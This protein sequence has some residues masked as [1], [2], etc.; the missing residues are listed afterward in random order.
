MD[1]TAAH[2]SRLALALKSCVAKFSKT[3]PRAPGIPIDTSI[4]QWDPSD[5]ERNI[6]E[7]SE[8]IPG[9]YS[10]F[11]QLRSNSPDKKQVHLKP[12]GILFMAHD[13]VS[14]LVEPFGVC[15]GTSI[16]VNT[17]FYNPI[18]GKGSFAK[19]IE[20]GRILAWYDHYVSATEA[21][22]AGG[23]FGGIGMAAASSD[24]DIIGL[25]L[26]TG[27]IRPV[28]I[29]SLQQLL[30]EDQELLNQYN[31]EKDKGDVVTMMK[32]VKLFNERNSL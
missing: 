8:R 3:D 12:R 26:K 32:Y 14:K 19:V 25:D 15:D 10:K 17:F 5:K 22:F 20:E 29:K 13:D 9:V 16:Y 18:S 1:V 31:R 24:I 27:L 6:L 28:K 21:G 23:A 7:C 4:E 2:D 11:A 30:I